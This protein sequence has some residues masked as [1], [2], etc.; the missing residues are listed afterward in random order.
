MSDFDFS[1]GPLPNER[2]PLPKRPRKEPIVL[3]LAHDDEPERRSGT[4]P[5]R[6]RLRSQRWSPTRIACVVISS[7]GVFGV[8][9]VLG[10]DTSVATGDGGRVHNIGLMHQQE[11][12][13]IVAVA[14]AVGGFIGEILC[15]HSD[16]D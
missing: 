8:V 9:S 3:S 13:L 5:R 2:P 1:E 16:V 4:K 6:P 11:M 14:A 7:L 12:L 10:M 15:R